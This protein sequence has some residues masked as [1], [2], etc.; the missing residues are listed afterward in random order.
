MAQDQLNKRII[1]RKVYEELVNIIVET[2]FKEFGND[3]DAR[4][5]VY[6][7]VAENFDGLARS[8]RGPGSGDPS[9]IDT[10]EYGDDDNGDVV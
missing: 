8:L 3:L 2:V 9:L 10:I 1:E 4:L 6:T 5:R 7:L